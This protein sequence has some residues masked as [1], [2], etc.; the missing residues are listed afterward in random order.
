MS[1]D[2]AVNNGLLVSGA[3]SFRGNIGVQQGR[4]A[5]LSNEPLEATAV[6]DAGGKIVVPGGI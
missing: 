2:L 4:I 1:Y 5:V 6:V 3:G